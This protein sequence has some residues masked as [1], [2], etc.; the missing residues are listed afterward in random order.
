M[1]TARTVVM[2]WQFQICFLNF[3]CSIFSLLCPEG[4][5]REFGWWSENSVSLL[6]FLKN[7]SNVDSIKW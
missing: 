5:Y 2:L 7:V 6:G 4:E 3:Q 1:L